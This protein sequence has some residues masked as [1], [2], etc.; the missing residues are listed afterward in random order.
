MDFGYC[1]WVWLVEYYRIWR[2]RPSRG[3]TG[4]VGRGA[5][6]RKRG[7]W[8]LISALLSPQQLG[9]YLL[10]ALDINLNKEGR[11][12]IDRAARAPQQPTN[13]P[14]GHQMSQQGLY[15]PEKSYFG[16]KIAPFGPN[17]IIILGGSKSFGTNISENHLGTSFAL[18]CGLAWHQMGQKGQY[19]AQNNQKCIFW[20]KFGRFSGQKS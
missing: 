7:Y 14:K 8:K 11:R 13:Q 1:S 10:S 12:S 5:V 16:A 19:L 9:W 15:V 18:F 3:G 20:A 2:G 4:S 17:I 6:G